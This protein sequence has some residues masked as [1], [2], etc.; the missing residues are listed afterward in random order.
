MPLKGHATT[1]FENASQKIEKYFEIYCLF[2]HRWIWCYKKMKE[3]VTFYAWVFHFRRWEFQR[4]FCI[5]FSKVIDDNRSTHMISS[6]S[7]FIL[8]YNINTRRQKFD[9]IRNECVQKK[10]LF[11]LLWFTLEQYWL[12]FH[13]QIFRDI[14]E[15]HMSSKKI[16]QMKSSKTRC[17]IQ[18]FSTF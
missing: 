15:K 14:A 16:P 1:T 10:T 3:Y 4:F 9:R 11:Q 5:V 6:F 8:Q 13:L 18:N 2:L 12:D 7:F 17:Y